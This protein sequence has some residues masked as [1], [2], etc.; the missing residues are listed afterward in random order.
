MGQ[1]FGMPMKTVHTAEDE[2]TTSKAS[3]SVPKIIQKKTTQG[4]K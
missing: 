3:N 4:K 1:G 2:I